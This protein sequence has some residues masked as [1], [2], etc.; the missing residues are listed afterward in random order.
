M[1]KVKAF[2]IFWDTDGHDAR[3][4]DLPT[5]VA[6][7]IDDDV[8]EIDDDVVIEAIQSEFGDWPINSLEF[9]IVED[10]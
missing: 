3:M 5:T 9:E 6:I 7:T 2:E 4:L 1:S 8:E 10:D